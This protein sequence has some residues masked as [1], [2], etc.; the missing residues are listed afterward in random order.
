[1]AGYDHSVEELRK[2]ADELW[3]RGFKDISTYVHNV[4]RM[5][6]ARDNMRSFDGY[7]VLA[8]WDDEG[9]Q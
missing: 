6:E 2:L 7:E 1:M 5:Q 9:G 4:A 3:E 8:R